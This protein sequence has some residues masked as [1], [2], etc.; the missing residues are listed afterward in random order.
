M[1]TTGFLATLTL[2][3]AALAFATQATHAENLRLAPGTPPA[4]PGH[5]PLFTS[6][7]DQLAE[8]TGNRMTGNILGTEVANLGNMRNAVTSGLADAGMFLPAYF[9]SDLPEINLVGDLSFQGTNSQAMGAAMT[10]YIVNCADCQENLKSLGIVYTS[11]HASD[12]YQLLTTEPVSDLDDMRGLRLRAGNPQY[13]RWASAMGASPSNTSV[14]ETFEAISQGILDGTIASSADLISFRL[15]DVITHITTIRLGTY[16]STI[17]HAFGRNSWARLSEADRKMLAES[18]SLSSALATQR[19]AHEMPAEA[20]ALAR[21]E[22]IEFVEPSQELLD[23]TATFVVDDM[24]Q[25]IADAESRYNLN[26]VPAKLEQ[27][28]TLVDKWTA[29]ANELDNDPE[30]IAERVNEEVWAKVDFSTY[31]VQ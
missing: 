21:S 15:D 25:V 24:A 17:S 11:S 27:F 9:P 5:T 23:A 13:A 30:A 7:Q 29:I 8:K 19:W 31:G 28:T 1:R 4:H 22:G 26:N 12:L 16:H 10:D 2:S 18:S 14:G 3:A 20:E 6:F